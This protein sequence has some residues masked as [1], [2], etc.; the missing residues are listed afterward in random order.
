[1]HGARL[2]NFGLGRET[3][4][5]SLYLDPDNCGNYSLNENA[6]PAHFERTTAD[7][8]EAGLEERKWLEHGT[9]IFYKSDTQGF[10]ET[11]ATSS[12]GAFWD[13]VCGGIFEL[14]RIPGKAYDVDEFARIIDRFPNKVFYKAP[15]VNVSSREVMGTRARELRLGHSGI[16]L[17]SNLSPNHAT[18]S[19][20]I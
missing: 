14:W 18:P 20:T 9:P 11:I 3:S 12:S 19:A 10:D 1:V 2:N 4:V 17:I 15:H 6:M 7:I 13:R 8:V 5:L 16:T